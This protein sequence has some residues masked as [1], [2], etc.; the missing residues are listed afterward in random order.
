MGEGLFFGGNDGISLNR[1]GS[2]QCSLIKKRKRSDYV[3][4]RNQSIKERQLQALRAAFVPQCQILQNLLGR[5][6]VLYNHTIHKKQALR[7]ADADKVWP[8]ADQ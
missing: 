8:L 3:L 1:M 5:R 6:I 7:I 4:R 2:S